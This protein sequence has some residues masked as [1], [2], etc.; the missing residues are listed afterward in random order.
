MKETALRVL[1]LITAI[2]LTA[3]AAHEIAKGLQASNPHALLLNRTDILA[4]EA[5]AAVDDFWKMSERESGGVAEAKLSEL[6][7]QG[8][9]PSWADGTGGR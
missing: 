3:A 5:A 7:A 9:L 1:D 6:K 2:R 8:L 4:T